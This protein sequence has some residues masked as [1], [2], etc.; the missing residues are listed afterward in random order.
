MYINSI[1]IF[2]SLI[3]N[4]TFNVFLQENIIVMEKNAGNNIRYQFKEK[5]FWAAFLNLARHN[6][7]VTINHINSVCG[8]KELENDDQ[9]AGI[10][11]TW[12]SDKVNKNLLL[13]AKLQD[14]ILK[15]FPFVLPATI[16]YASYL[17]YN[18]LGSDNDK[19]KKKGN[20][21]KRSEQSEAFSYENI[22]TVLFDLLAYLQENRNY[23]SHFKHAESQE[24]PIPTN[25]LIE[26]LYNIFEA[27]IQLVKTDYKQNEK[28]DAHHSF[29]HLIRK[30]KNGERPDFKYKF[31]KED[32]INENGLLFFTSLFLQK[33]D[34][35]WMQKKLYGFKGADEEWKKMTNEVF[36]RSRVL[37]PKLRLESQYD[38]HQMLLDMLNE[39]ARCPKAL[40]DRLKTED[41]ERFKVKIEINDDDEQQEPDNYEDPF[42]NTLIRHENRFPYFALRYFDLKEIFPKLRFQ[43]DLGNYHFSIYDKMVGLQNEK[44]H[45][46]RH[47]YGFDRIQNFSEAN[48]PE[49][50]KEL[51]KDLDYFES[52]E[53][54]FISKSTP[55]YHFIQNKIGIKFTDGTCK[56]PSLKVI[57]NT[58]PHKIKY[59]YDEKL[60]ADAFLSTHELLP[61]M[62]YHFLIKD[63]DGFGVEDLINQTIKCIKKVYDLFAKNEINTITDLEKAINGTSLQVGHFPKSMLNI[64]KEDD[65]KYMPLEAKRKINELIQQTENRLTKLNDQFNKKIRP[66]KRGAGLLKPGIIADWLVNDFMRFQPVAYD[67]ENKPM[68]KSKAD[69]TEF[70]LLQR[71]FALYGGEKDRIPAYFNQ[72]RLVNSEN[73]HAFMTNFKWNEQPNILAFYYE[74]LKARKQFLEKLNCEKWREYQHFLLLKEPKTNRKTL[75]DGWT[76]GLNLPR[77]IFTEAIREWLLQNGTE[78]LTEFA[79]KTERNGFVAR[80]VPLY[81]KETFDDE[82]Q[83]FYNLPF[84]IENP[85]KSDASFFKTPDERITIWNER[86]QSIDKRKMEKA[87]ESALQE[88]NDILNEK[89]RINVKKEKLSDYFNANNAPYKLKQQLNGF[90]NFKKLEKDVSKWLKEKWIIPYLNFHSWQL[91]EKELRMCKNQD[92]LVWLMCLD[93]NKAGVE[94]LE[95][96][97]LKLKNINTNIDDGGSLNA[98]NRET[99][100]SQL[101][102]VYPATDTGTV[103]TKETPLLQVKVYEMHTK[104]LKQGNF[105]ALMKDRRINSLFSFID[106]E[107]LTEIPT[108]SKK[109]LEF[110]LGKYQTMRVDAFEITLDIE[111]ELLLAND[112]FPAN[113]FR[114]M[115]FKW[116]ETKPKS[117]EL[118]NA[119]NVA[120]A[121]RNAISHNQYP[122]YNEEPFSEICKFNPG[123]SNVDEKDGLG[124]ALQLSEELKK[125]GNIILKK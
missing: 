121:I 14:L 103:L 11:A 115:L 117:E 20:S 79:Q 124:I 16:G 60:V 84:N 102:N 105:K 31:V 91:F 118:N 19:K 88:V 40:Y 25:N 74:Y 83:A 107:G 111:K 92:M 104:V 109:R 110:E 55:H 78:T 46:T 47:L 23:F 26:R 2:L 1:L 48:Q 100:M 49:K 96:E 45:L 18:N 8:W 36:C 34:A 81:L 119:V 17:E 57:D 93:L 5:H 61:M 85:K 120:I 73:P 32:N 97:G 7:Y 52:S 95:I 123:K 22:T 90:I 76:D 89:T 108:I 28:V 98:L 39:L 37:I 15:H 13:K 59:R 106:T 101:F 24:L 33:K 68:P 63:N 80:A 99:L 87:Y 112:K 43:I 71:T 30:D 72:C 10:K 56:W 75:V 86:K 6:V 64:L 44:R 113:N 70:Q 62:F 38:S 116:K 35:I 21:E 4:F 77:G 94:T 3:F 50:W 65:K 42:K 9:I 82:I 66:G 12:T 41:K 54:P 53:L 67:K 125:A 114:E 27:N 58:D 29:K 51:V 122:F 69:S